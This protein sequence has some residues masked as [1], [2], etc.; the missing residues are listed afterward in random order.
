VTDNTLRPEDIGVTKPAPALP[1]GRALANP[2]DWLPTNPP[3]KSTEQLLAE[4]LAE[5]Q[6]LNAFLR[7]ARD[8]ERGK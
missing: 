1:A 6:K 5:L 3:A 4:I 8:A 2:D 7:S